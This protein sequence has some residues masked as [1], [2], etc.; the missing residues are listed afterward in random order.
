[1]FC[2]PNYINVYYGFGW[3]L[4]DSLSKEAYVSTLC[5]MKIVSSLDAGGILHVHEKTS[6]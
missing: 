6:K 3:L 5:Q 1:M 4:N 2:I